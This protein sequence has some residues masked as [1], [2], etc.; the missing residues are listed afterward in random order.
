MLKPHTF[1][2]DDFMVMVNAG[3]FH[4]QRVELLD[5]VIVDM[6]PSDP[7]HEA[8]I[9]EIAENLFRAFV[10][11]ARVRVQNAIDVELSEWLLHPDVTLVKRKDYSAVR[12]RPDD[13]YLL[14][15]VA[16]TS[17][18]LDKGRKRDI[19]AQTGIKDYWIADLTTQTW[20]VHREPEG[21]RY[22]VVQEILFGQALAPLAFPDEARVWL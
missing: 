14:I 11:R 9:D 19:Y 18:E 1:T 4:D 20:L 5:G 21:Q 12:P 17:L 2:M 15:E 8:A 6:S 3:L 10:D 22:T 7:H 16:N 13:I